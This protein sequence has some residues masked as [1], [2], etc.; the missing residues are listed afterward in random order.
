M[1][2]WA[3]P[4]ALSGLVMLPWCLVGQPNVSMPRFEAASIKPAAEP[5]WAPTGPLATMLPLVASDPGQRA[6]PMPDPGRV[7]IRSLSLL[8]LVAMAYGVPVAQVRGPSWMGQGAFEVDATVPAGA[9]KG[10]VKVMLQSLLQE[11][12]SL[13][14]HHETEVIPG[15][16]LMLGGGGSKLTPSVMP[17]E[18][19]PGQDQEADVRAALS[20]KVMNLAANQTV[21]PPAGTSRSQFAHVSTAQLAGI[22]FRFVQAPVVDETGLKGTYDVTLEISQ[23]QSGD[24]VFDALEKLG[25]KLK[26]RPVPTDALVID[27][28]TRAPTPN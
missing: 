28:A 18:P 11:R 8:G 19:P 13:I 12:F 3:S 16:A 21:P 7:R 20:R 23:D 14:A 15:Y 10:Q 2:R 26:A 9:Q 22:L 27:R 5:T 6:I 4:A 24:S 25:L 17:A 1:R